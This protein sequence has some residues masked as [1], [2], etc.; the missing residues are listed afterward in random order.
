MTEDSSNYNLGDQS[1]DPEII[2]KKQINNSRDVKSMAQ[3]R[4]ERKEKMAYINHQKM[5]E[6]GELQRK[7]EEEKQK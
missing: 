2:T 1:T 5:V 6:S 7:I 4:A 3:K